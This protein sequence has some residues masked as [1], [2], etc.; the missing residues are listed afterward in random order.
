MH[1]GW[2]SNLL[3][4]FIVNHLMLGVSQHDVT[5]SLSRGEASDMNITCL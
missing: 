4:W 2:Q 1:G 5:Y 3:S